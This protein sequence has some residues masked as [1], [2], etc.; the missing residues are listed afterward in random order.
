MRGALSPRAT[1]PTRSI[2]RFGVRALLGCTAVAVGIV[3]FLVL[4]SLVRRSWAPLA[5]VDAGVAAG[6]NDAVS[7]EPVLVRLLS[8]VTALGGTGTA[9]LS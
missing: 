4:W 8:A 1:A 9:V 6:L 2:G 3:P 5:D 7:G